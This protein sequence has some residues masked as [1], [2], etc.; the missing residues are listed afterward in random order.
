[1]VMAVDGPPGSPSSDHFAFVVV[2]AFRMSL[3]S[4]ILSLVLSFASSDSFAFR[5][6]LPSLSSSPSPRLP[7]VD[8]SFHYFVSFACPPLSSF[9]CFRTRTLLSLTPVVVA[10]F[11]RHAASALC[12]VGFMLLSFDVSLLLVSLRFAVYVPLSFTS[13]YSFVSR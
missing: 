13:D 9:S 3:L 11:F 4:L 5:L 12:C 2:T 7:R 1:V 8:S 10:S 6:R